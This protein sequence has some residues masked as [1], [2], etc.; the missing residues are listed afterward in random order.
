[1]SDPL[2]SMYPP[3]RLFPTSSP[4]IPPPQAAAGPYMYTSSPR[5]L[6]FPSQ[7]PPPQQTNDYYVGHVLPPTEAN[8]TCI[9]APVG[10]GFTSSRGVE[11]A[12]V[13]DVPVHN[14]EEGLNWGRR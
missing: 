5:M 3:T 6:S 13:G 4:Y 8:Y 2:R 9:G 7:Y 1:M 10:H 11:G 14:Q 12:G